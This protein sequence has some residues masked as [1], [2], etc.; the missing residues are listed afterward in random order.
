[1]P[2]DEA[3]KM[4]NAPENPPVEPVQTPTVE[5]PVIDTPAPA[6]KYEN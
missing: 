2:V 4:L 1:M 5:S 3:I 6:E